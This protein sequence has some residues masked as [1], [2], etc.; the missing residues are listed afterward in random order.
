MS[1]FLLLTVGTWGDVNPFIGIGRELKRRGHQV[2][3]MANER[4]H[5]RIGE[6]G[7]EAISTGKAADYDRL[8]SSP[9]VWDPK[10]GIGVLFKGHILPEL[11]SYYRSVEEFFSRYPNDSALVGTT[12]GLAGRV[13]QE[14]LGIPYATL[15]L[16]PVNFYSRYETPDYGPPLS[17][18][19]PWIGPW[20]RDWVMNKVTAQAD[21]SFRKL[22]QFRSSLGLE[23]PIRG[24]LK[25]WRLSP[26]LNIGLWPQ[27]FAG[28]QSD[29]P[30]NTHLTGFIEEDSGASDFDLEQMKDRP[31]IFTA[32]TGMN[33]GSDFYAAAAEACSRLGLPGLLVTQYPDQLPKNLPK[34]VRH[35]KYAPF[36]EIAPLARALV[37]HGGMGTTARALAAGIPHVVMPMAF[38][39]FDNGSRLKKLG[40]G[41]VIPRSKINGARL[42][43]ALDQLL[44]SKQTLAKC[45]KIAGDMNADGLNPTCDLLERLPVRAQ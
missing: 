44:S 33:S 18:I 38:D 45:Q 30:R 37:H 16:Q 43:Q 26:E 21:H 5:A 23:P 29:W 17:S 3:I 19:F 15:S 24:I 32:G 27:W 9:K 28:P 35:L 40:V 14:K 39:Q 25:D 1:K 22:N 12:I 4:Y 42:A 10:K 31:I 13:A 41:Q 8:M 34:G 36:K 20:G 6:E 11:G 2:S 7:F